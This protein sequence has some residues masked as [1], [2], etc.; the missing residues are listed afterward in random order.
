CAART[1][2]AEHQHASDGRHRQLCPERPARRCWRQRTRRPA[3]RRQ[4][5]T[6]TWGLRDK[7]TVM[8]RYC[9]Q[10]NQPEFRR[11]TSDGVRPMVERRHL[12]RQRGRLRRP[13]RRHQPTAYQIVARLSAGRTI[14]SP[15]LQP[16]AFANSGMLLSGPLTRHLAGACGFV[17][18][19][20]LVAS[21]LCSVR[22]TCA[23]P[24]KKRCSGVNPSILPGRPFCASAFSIA[25]YA[26]LRPPRSPRFSPSVSL[27]F[28]CV[29]ESTTV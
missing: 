11:E 23:H 12:S 15:S 2:S 20:A 16:H 14:A 25:R 5:E 6:S 8:S 10:F 18:T 1:H 7:K 29:V 19:C 28:T 13:M 3:L 4:I 24:R 17:F 27:P 22:H 26:I 21:S 9:T